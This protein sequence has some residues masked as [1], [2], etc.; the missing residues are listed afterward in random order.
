MKNK[1]NG[2]FELF[3]CKQIK[4]ARKHSAYVNNAGQ[5]VANKIASTFNG[6][7]AQKRVSVLIRKRLILDELLNIECKITNNT[8]V[9]IMC[10]TRD[11][12]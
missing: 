1:K 5:F 11:N 9:L 8:D 10:K 6:C 12:K 2:T 3:K 7:K 4:N